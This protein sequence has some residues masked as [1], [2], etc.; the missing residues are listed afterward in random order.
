MSNTEGIVTRLIHAAAYYL[1]EHDFDAYVA[2]F[3]EDAEYSIVT[4]APELPKPMIWMQRTKKELAERLAAASKHEWQILQ[5][6]QTRLVSVNKLELNSDTVSSLSNFVVYNTDEKGR[7]ECFAV[8]RY[9]DRWS[10]KDEE[11]LIEERKVILK[12]RLLSSHT[13]LPI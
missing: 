2:L 4:S 6:E 13:A 5:Q 9:E 11:C 3:A 12:T 7:S 1:D 8:G 10:I